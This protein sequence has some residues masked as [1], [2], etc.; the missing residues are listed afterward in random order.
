MSDDLLTRAKLAQGLAADTPILSHR[1]TD[2]AIIFVANLGIKGCPKYVVLRDALPEL[3]K[4]ETL[5]EEDK[6]PETLPEEEP[7][8]RRTR[9]SSK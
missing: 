5:P 4:P 2:T 7:T 8:R 3:P 9:R 1:I 6:E